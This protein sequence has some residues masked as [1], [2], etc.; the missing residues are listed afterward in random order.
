MEKVIVHGC[1]GAGISIVARYI[2][3]MKDDELLNV[4][5]RYLDTSRADISRFENLDS[6]DIH[7]ITSKKLGTIIDGSGGRRDTN[8][9]EIS[10]N[11]NEY[12]NKVKY[13]HGE[14]HI[15]VSSASGASGSVLSSLL[16]M[17]LR[18][19]NVPVVFI[20]ITD[21]TSVKYAEHSLNTL[22]Y[23]E[24]A[25]KKYGYKIPTILIE[26]N[27]NRDNIDRRVSLQIESISIMNSGKIKSLDTMD[28]KLFLESGYDDSADGGI[29]T[30]SIL[31]GGMDAIKNEYINTLRI[32]STDAALIPDAKVGQ[33][34]VC[35]IDMEMVDKLAS[36]S[37]ST[38]LY[39]AITN[40][41]NIDKIIKIKE[42]LEIKKSSIEKKKSF[43]DDEDEID[44]L[45]I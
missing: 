7:I 9:A 16:I 37:L 8:S 4:E 40:T 38:P 42:E 3:K 39:F 1:G 31:S 44:G 25:G 15:V 18:K 26:N 11:I 5:T 28:T 35:V 41:I 33:Y 24:L 23:V 13:E 27:G 21:T 45:M 32:L 36:M 30:L 10:E 34:K 20:A 17:G 2:E 6:K 14:V 22:K 43:L 19:M 12:I 29:Y